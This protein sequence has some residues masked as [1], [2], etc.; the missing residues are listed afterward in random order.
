MIDGGAK[1]MSGAEQ[2]PNQTLTMDIKARTGSTVT[3]RFVKLLK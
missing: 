3:P 2:I 1:Q